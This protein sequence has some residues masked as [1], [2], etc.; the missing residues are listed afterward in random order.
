MTPSMTP[1]EIRQ[2][3]WEGKIERFK[4]SNTQTAGNGVV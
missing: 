4:E 2:H 1:A 3:Y